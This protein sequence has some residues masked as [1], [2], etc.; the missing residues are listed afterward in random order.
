MIIHDRDLSGSVF[1]WTAWK[2]PGVFPIRGAGASLFSL[3][4]DVEDLAQDEIHR[5]PPGQ[6]GLKQIG[7]DKSGQPKPPTIDPEPQSQ[8][9]QH[10][11]PCK[12]PDDSFAIH[13]LKPRFA[14]IQGNRRHCG[15]FSSGDFL[16]Q[17]LC[18]A[19]YFT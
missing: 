6:G 10:K 17:L 8:A 9:E 15:L 3:A 19:Y 7:P 11:R 1:A 16:M 18:H 12:K 4:T 2:A 13:G 5:T 14:F